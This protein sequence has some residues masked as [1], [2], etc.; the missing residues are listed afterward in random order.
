MP[1]NVHPMLILSLHYINL[2]TTKIFSINS[3]SLIWSQMF[4]FVFQ[5]RPNLETM[6]SLL[7]LY[8]CTS[9]K[10]K[11]SSTSSK[12]HLDGIFRL[13]HCSSVP[14]LRFFTTWIKVIFPTRASF[15]P[16]RVF[17][18][19]PKLQEFKIWEYDQGFH[20]GLDIKKTDLNEYL[21][22]TIFACH[23]FVPIT[24]NGSIKS[25]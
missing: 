21:K 7:I 1:K 23:W 15:C 20:P 2:N 9:T 17:L 10:D 18:T 13:V 3:I 11:H 24:I 12:R 19:F 22:I 16:V 5:E 14:L 8:P 4:I 25:Y 6:H